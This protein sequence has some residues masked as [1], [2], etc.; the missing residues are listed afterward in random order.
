MFTKDKAVVKKSERKYEVKIKTN[1]VNSERM[2][3][4]EKYK[5]QGKKIEET[6]P[7]PKREIL[8]NYRYLE[9]KF[10]KKDDERRRSIV[11]HRRLG[12]PIGKETEY[13]GKRYNSQTN[14]K[15]KIPIFNDMKKEKKFLNQNEV[16]Q[17]TALNSKNYSQN[18]K[19]TTYQVKPASQNSNIISNQ[20]KIISTVN[21]KVVQNNKNLQFKNN[22][23]KIYNKSSLNQQKNY[24]N[25]Q[26]SLQNK[27]KSSSNQMKKEKEK[28]QVNY[29][30]Q[31]I[32]NEASSSKIS[33]KQIDK[34]FNQVIQ[35]LNSPQQKNEVKEETSPLTRITEICK[36]CGKPKRLK[37]SYNSEKSKTITK[38]EIIAEE[39]ENGNYIIR[40]GRENETQIEP[41]F[42][43]YRA[44][45]TH[46]CPIH[47]YV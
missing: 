27:E 41:H 3:E 1:H 35:S 47:G 43:T 19:S 11:K 40:Y 15:T 10:I 36:T 14:Y 30:N 26:K 22:N 20:K 42:E 28:G 9:T 25:P 46:F 8:D 13:S 21:S 31:K 44:P 37:D 4:I 39:Q 6:K 18:D 33:Q 24:S 2:N 34:R 45:G 38:K 32:L 17:K 16:R 29:N 23:E 12:K 5:I 7:K